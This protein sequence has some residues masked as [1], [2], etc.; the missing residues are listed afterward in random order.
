MRIIKYIICHTKCIQV[1]QLQYFIGKQKWGWYTP[2]RMRTEYLKIRILYNSIY[3]LPIYIPYDN[4]ISEYF[5]AI[6]LR[7]SFRIYF[8]YHIYSFIHIYNFYILYSFTGYSLRIKV[9]KRE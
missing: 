1:L 4:T 3:I 8:F 7:Y 5:Q 2:S 9:R 6:Y